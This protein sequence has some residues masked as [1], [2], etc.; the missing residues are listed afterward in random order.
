MQWQDSYNVGVE[1]V[2]DAHRR[3][4]SI[5]R[6]L[7]EVTDEKDLGKSRRVS[8]EGIKYFKNYTVEH[9]A[10]EEGYMRKV[11]YSGYPAH[12]RL[13][14]E[15]REVTIPALEAMLEEAD[16]SHEAVE[17]FLGACLGWLTGHIMV[18]DQSITGKVESRVHHREAEEDKILQMAN[19][20][21][22]VTEEFFEEEAVLISRYFAGENLQSPVCCRMTYGAGGNEKGEKGPT[23]LMSFE[24]ELV[25]HAVG[26]MSGIP[27]TEINNIVLSAMEQ[28]MQMM[29]RRIAFHFGVAE[30]IGGASELT[31]LDGEELQKIYREQPPKYSLL[32]DTSYGKFSFSIQ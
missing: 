15:M 5:V 14:D 22:E 28:M 23:V 13:H 2:D 32:F 31:L 4:F 20:L 17:K 3:L 7:M 30:M 16:Y 25:F 26:R 8:I 27:F 19:I 18:E 6:K 9:F 12:K 24:P 1:I 10:Q 11:G 21:S 29:S